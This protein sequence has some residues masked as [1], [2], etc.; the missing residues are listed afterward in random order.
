MQVNCE[1]KPIMG[2]MFKPARFPD[3]G[4]CEYRM[5]DGTKMLLVES[6]QS[7]AN[8][9]K[10]T[11]IDPDGRYAGNHEGLPFVETDETTSLMEQHRLVSR[12]LLNAGVKEMLD[13]E[14]PE[15]PADFPDIRDFARFCFR[16]DPNSV[17][18]GCWARGYAG[19]QYRLLHY[20]N[21]FIDAEGVSRVECPGI[22]RDTNPDVKGGDGT[23]IFNNTMYV[24]KSITL[25]FILNDRLLESYELGE[26]AENLLRNMALWRLNKLLSRHF[27][28]RSLCMLEF[29]GSDADIPDVPDAEIPRL[30]ERCVKAG[31][32]DAKPTVL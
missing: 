24:A 10:S 22:R 7:M 19:D 8:W 12:R 15:A 30:A 25:H 1:L 14:L 20:I 21:S 29:V 27:I 2:D 13:E 26:D 4:H 23:V 28:P 5:S 16:H 17:L 18:Y 11:V 6:K 32:L 3:T 9:L 31:V